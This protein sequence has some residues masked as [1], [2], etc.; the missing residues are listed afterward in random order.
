MFEKPLSIPQ[1]A[2]GT[3]GV[4]EWIEH[5]MIGHKFHEFFRI[6]RINPA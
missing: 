1:K 3:P 2:Y 6:A 4:I 5:E